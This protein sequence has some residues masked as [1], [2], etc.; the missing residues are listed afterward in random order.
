MNKVIAKFVMWW[1][2]R[3]LKKSRKKSPWNRFFEVK[4]NGKH[5]PRYLLFTDVEYIRN[6]LESM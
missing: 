3:E 6:S 4:G 5:Y 2:T 1:C